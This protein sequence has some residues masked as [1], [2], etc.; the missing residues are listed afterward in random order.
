MNT[1]MNEDWQADGLERFIKP[2]TKIVVQDSAG[3]RLRIAKLNF[4]ARDNTVT[5][6]L[7]AR[8]Q[9]QS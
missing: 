1:G 2:D 6:T 7:K 4:E 5:I 9:V 8:K 3:S